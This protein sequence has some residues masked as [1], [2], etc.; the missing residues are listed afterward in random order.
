MV[1]YVNDRL[2]P[3]ARLYLYAVGN[4]GY[5]LKRDFYSD[6][7][8]E[9]YLFANLLRQSESAGEFHD[10]WR[11][12]GFTHILLSEKFLFKP[13]TEK[14]QALIQD[15]VRRHLRQVHKSGPY[16]LFEIL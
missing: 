2:D 15:F 12:R 9:W 3:D 13:F 4:R 14:E 11:K 6:S 16:R 1:W 8:F 7:V 10:K 5:Y